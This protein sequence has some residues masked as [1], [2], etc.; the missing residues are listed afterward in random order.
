MSELKQ[1]IL[2][3]FKGPTLCAFAT[4]TEEGKPRVRYTTPTMDENLTIWMA[5]FANSR[6]IPQIKNNPEV[7]ITSGVGSF[8]TA[9]SWVQIEA[10]AEI[11]YDEETKNKVWDDH[12]KVAF[13]GPDDPNYCICK[14]T[15]YR[16]EYHKMGPNPA[17]VWEA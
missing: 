3:K 5:T 4:V 9:E 8:E 14:I 7:H 11:L 6:K 13:S 16:I 15:P 1:K 12:L 17:E 2:E 10:K